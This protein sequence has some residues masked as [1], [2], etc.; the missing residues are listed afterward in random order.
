MFATIGQTLH[1]MKL[2]WRV[3][4]KDRELLWFP[5]MAGAV[6]LVVV[7][8]AAALGA[9]LGTFER[10]GAENGAGQQANAA[11]VALGVIVYAAGTFVV[12]FF[13]SALIAA[14]IERLRGGDPNVSSGLQV[15]LANVA[16][17]AAWALI[18]ATVGLILQVLRNRTDNILGRIAIALV[19]GAW[20]Y[21]TFF[22]VPVLVTEG[23]GPVEAIRR[24]G[25]LFRRTWGQQAVSGF[26]FGIVYVG[27]IFVAL[28]PSILLFALMPA[29]GVVVAVPLFAMAIG[30]VMAL[31]GIFKA[32]LFEFANDRNPLEFDRAT[33]S[34][35]Y[36]AL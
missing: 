32:A 30:T 9:S 19:G 10:L 23:I 29:L 11:D 17:I 2:S 33:L 12:I 5:I 7:A 14:A 35:A 27:A 8:I 28:L 1:L 3:L 15:A 4:M 20:A 22:V 34:M 21:M 18:A 6:L 26:G 36:R 24:S 13:N 31:E 25:S 16:A